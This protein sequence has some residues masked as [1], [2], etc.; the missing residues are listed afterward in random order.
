MG[1]GYFPSVYIWAT[2][3]LIY[4][5]GRMQDSPAVSPGCK[6]QGL[7]EEEAL[8]PPATPSLQLPSSV[9]E[10]QLPSLCS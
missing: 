9:R 3:R 5:L 8:T 10:D 4:T 2:L 6:G 7:W 1:Q